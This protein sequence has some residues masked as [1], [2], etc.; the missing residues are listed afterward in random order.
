VDSLTEIVLP[1]GTKFGL[2]NVPADPALLA[3]FPVYGDTAKT[4][5]IPRSEWKA[6]VDAMG[7]P[8]PDAPFLSPVHNQSSIG[9]CNASATASAMESQRAKQGLPYRQLSAG[10]LYRRIC[11]NG[12]DSGST[13]QDGIRAAMADGIATTKTVPY[14][15]WRRDAVGAATERAENRVLEAFVCPS[16]DHVYSAVLCGYDIISG[17]WWYDG[18]TPGADGWL[19]RP[20]GNRGGHAVHGF[21]PTYRG[22]EF[23][24]WH[25]N[26]WTERW[27]LR[28]L[29]VFPERSYDAGGINGWWAVRSVT[30]EGGVVPAG[31]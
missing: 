7:G 23:G 20:S 9:M 19:P 14:L 15:E 26:S 1:D 11:F 6:R 29:C 16:F 3:S 25:K 2:G 5:L 31:A 24:V 27:G 4:P 17:I 8:G 21:K 30:D 12:R 10:D 28:G 22:T 13:L 18:Y